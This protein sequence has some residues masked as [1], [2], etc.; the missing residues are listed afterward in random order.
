MLALVRRPTDM[1][2]ATRWLFAVLALV[3]LLITWPAPLA[4]A[5]GTMLL[6]ALACSCVLAGSWV[7]GYAHRTAPLASDLI[8]AVAI[9]GFALACPEPGAAFS[10]VFGSLWFRSLYGST[11]RAVLRTGLYAGAILCSLPLW[12]TVAGHAE[13]AGTAMLLGAIPTMFVTVIVGRHLAAILHAREQAARR[14]AV[15][16]SAG[17]RLLGLTD[18]DEIRAVARAAIGEIGAATDGLRVIRVV[19]DG[20]ALLVA[21]ASGTAV[22]RDVAL[23]D[24]VLAE[25]LAVRSGDAEPLHHWPALDSV[26]GARCAWTSMPVPDTS[27]QPSNVWL[28]LGAPT[29]VPNEVVVSILAFTTQVALALRSSEVHGQLTVQATLDGL[30]ALAN[31]SSFNAELTEALVDKRLDPTSVLFVDLDDFKD[32]N[33]AYGHAGG[34]ELLQEIAARLVRCTRPNDLCARLGGDEFAIL[35]RG[36]T[37]DVVDDM[38]ERVVASVA[39]PVLLANGTALVGASVGVA[40]GTTETDPDQLVH[41]AD[42]AMYAAKAK[43]KGRI[44]VFVPGL[45]QEDS[46]HSGPGRPGAGLMAR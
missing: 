36:A 5:G 6:V 43:G 23:P 30:T 38:A 21:G 42:V 20:S 7:W 22:E 19:H 15:L 41:R 26:V 33:D 3:S 34:D 14:D 28:L 29:R 46:S 40:T 25:L 10:I 17:T 18:P 4:S 27:D 16:A 35:V 32:V 39:Q 11:R 45:L 37:A 12:Q 13:A 9:G 1:V 31:R 2:E 8:D 44:Q 24:V